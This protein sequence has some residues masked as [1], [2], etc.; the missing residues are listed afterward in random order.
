MNKVKIFA[1]GFN[2]SGTTSIYKLLKIMKYNAIHTPMP[3]LKIIDKY[4]AF[5]D[6]NHTNFIDYYNKYPNSLFILNTRPIKNWL[7]SR[8]KHGLLTNFRKSWCWPVEDSKTLKWINDRK[9][10]HMNVLKFFKDKPKQLLVVN[11]EENNWENKIYKFIK[12]EKLNKTLKLKIH[13]NQRSDTLI[14]KDKMEIIL[15][16]VNNC[17]KE[18]NYNG[19][20]I[21]Y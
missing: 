15:N 14:V 5:T 17:L 10:H 12:Q 19:S 8:Y 13:S 3:V 21:L 6:G 20:E 11:I 2:K 4:D 16:S 9:I 1:I 7:V 18:C